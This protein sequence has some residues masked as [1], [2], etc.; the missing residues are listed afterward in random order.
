MCEDWTKL[1]DPNFLN[2]LQKKILRIAASL[3][4]I[5]IKNKNYESNWNP[6]PANFLSEVKSSIPEVLNEFLDDVLEINESDDQQNIVT[7]NR[8][9]STTDRCLKKETSLIQWFL[10]YI[11]T[12]LY[13][14]YSC[15]SVP[16]FIEKLV[17]I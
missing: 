7:N 9:V 13:P 2:D 6:P 15:R 3:I 1:C 12:L 8:V 5:G 4:K 11:Q 17:R 14:P 10:C 16:T